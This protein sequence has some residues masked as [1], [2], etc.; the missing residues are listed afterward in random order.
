MPPGQGL[1][2]LNVGCGR[3][4]HPAW[5]NIDVVSY[6]PRVEAHDLRLGLPAKPGQYDMVYHS[7]VLEHL[8]PADGQ[9]LI[10][11]CYRVLK[12]GGVLRIVVPDLEYIAR[13]Y[14]SALEEAC[15]EPED[16][17]T[18]SQRALRVAKYDWI[19]LELL[20]Q[21]VRQT[22]GG[23]MG[24]AM[25]TATGELAAFIGHRLG[26]EVKYANSQLAEVPAGD[27]SGQTATPKAKPTR[28]PARVRWARKIIKW[29]LGKEALKWLDVG[30]FLDS[31]EVHRWMYDRFSLQELT[32]RCRF[33]EFRV[34]TASESYLLGFADF[35]LD[36]VGGVVRKPDSIF[37]ECRKPQ[38]I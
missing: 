30:Q 1:Q 17:A 12:P 27:P 13:S 37:T 29:M 16:P 35:E 5:R 4:F 38:K 36:Q 26:H 3:H 8:T 21:L 6:D 33:R 25:Q 19:K 11:E 14:I 2:L 34:C 32:R 20:D 10:E 24:P 22:S 23:L 28:P 9:R 18:E 15:V 31:G 7:H